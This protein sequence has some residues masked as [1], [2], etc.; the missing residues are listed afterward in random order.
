MLSKPAVMFIT[1]AFMGLGA[2]AA[3]AK[4]LPGQ[5]LE[6]AGATVL[7]AQTMDWY[8]DTHFV[9][10][11]W[12][13]TLSFFRTPGPNEWGPV[14]V[15][16]MVVPSGQGVEMV[17]ALDGDT[18]VSTDGREAL[19]VWNASPTDPDDF[20]LG[21]RVAFNAAHGPAN[22]GLAH[23]VAGQNY[24]VT[25]HE[26]GFVLIWAIG[27]DGALTLSKEIDVRSSA[28]PSNPWGLHNVRGLAVW[29]DS[30]VVTGSEDGDIVGLNLPD[31]AERFRVRYNDKAQRGINNISIVGDLLLVA[32]CAVGFGDKNVWLF[33]L[34]SGAPVL[35]DAE[36]LAVD[37]T[38]SQVFNFDADLDVAAGGELVFYSSTEEGLLW[39]GSV[40][41]G[42]LV[43][44]GV[45]KVSPEGG[46]IIDVA[47]QSDMV[48]TATFAIRLFKSP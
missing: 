37:L 19:A 44:T 9:I 25:G 46:S 21:Q 48:A 33:D 8:D 20:T 23:A 7:F 28:A 24:L 35:A 43:V 14:A 47:P 10:G 5:T 29:G 4:D 26:D 6:P 31:G 1:A 15:E 41:N 27:T 18:I 38:R 12:D 34:A 42:Q 45:T 17:V 2:S 22:S 32:N 13:G 40:T 30:T 16:A 3:P 11:R 39:M 36:N